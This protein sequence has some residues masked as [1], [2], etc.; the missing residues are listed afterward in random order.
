[1]ELTN[2]PIRREVDRTWSISPRCAIAVR[3]MPF[4]RPLLPRV[5]PLGA[6]VVAC[7]LVSPPAV[8][9]S[10]DFTLATLPYQPA[11]CA[12]EMDPL[13]HD[14]CHIA[15]TPSPDG[16]RTLV[17]FLHGVIA[18]NTMWQWLQ[19]RGV[20]RSAKLLH[21]EAIVPQAPGVGPDAAGGYAWPGGHGAK[22]TDEDA[23]IRGWTRARRQ[24]EERN[25]HPF[26]E[27]YVVGFS[28]GAYFATSLAVRAK[29][30]VDGYVVL[31]GGS[32]NEPPPG[33]RHTPVFVGVCAKDR[34]SAP[35]ARELGHLLAARGWA[36]RIDEQPVGHGVNDVHMVHALGWLRANHANGNG[37]RSVR[38]ESADEQTQR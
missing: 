11:W 35:A 18:K 27:V 2:L 38:D 5:A 36:T 10:D 3:T 7:A 1:V 22:G 9:R 26:D 6:L 13:G 32:P 12:P 25:G 14:V 33:A 30:D 17:I 37:K 28:S 34:A 19:E 29:L 31:A 23:L 15:G 20:A 8:G 16:R 4:P 21:F 24:L